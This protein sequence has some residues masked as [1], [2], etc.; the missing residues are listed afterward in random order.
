M[1]LC[2]ILAVVMVFAFA[3]T[4]LPET[5]TAYADEPPYG[6][7]VTLIGTDGTQLGSLGTATAYLVNNELAASG[8]LGEDGCTAFM[9]VDNAV[10][11][12]QNY[13][14][15]PIAQYTSSLSLKVVIAGT[16]TINV[17]T[18]NDLTLFGLWARSGLIEITSTTGGTLNINVTNNNENKTGSI[19]G[20]GAGMVGGEYYGQVKVSGDA[21]VNV[22]V[23]NNSTYGLA[24]TNGIAVYDG[25]AFV[26]SSNVSIRVK[27]SSNA[28]NAAYAIYRN[29]D[30][31]PI[32]FD[33]TGNVTLDN[34]ESIIDAGYNTLVIGANY[35][36]A[37]VGTIKCT[38]LKDSR[39]YGYET[40]FYE[41]NYIPDLPSTVVRSKYVVGDLVTTTYKNKSTATFDIMYNANGGTGMMSETPKPYNVN[42]R[43]LKNQ[44]AAP[45]HMQFKCWDVNGEEIDAD[46]LIEITSDKLIKA[47]WETAQYTISFDANGGSGSIADIVKEYGDTCALPANS[48]L[49]APQGQQ[50]KCW[51]IAGVE[52][53]V[54]YEFTVAENVTVLAVWEDI[55]VETYTVTYKA[56]GGSGEDVVVNDLAGTY[57]PAANTF[58]APEHQRFAGWATTADGKVITTPTIVV[59]A[60]IELFAIWQDITFSITFAAEDGSGSMPVVNVIEDGSYV[61]P[62]NAFTAPAGKQF[63]GWN[64]FGKTY[65]A[66]YELNNINQDLRVAAIWEDIPVDPEPEYHHDTVDGVEVYGDTLTAGVAK[67]VAALFAEAKAENGKV[68]LTLDTLSISFNTAAVSAIGDAAA[69]ISANVLTSD[70]DV[71]GAQM[72]IEINLTGATFESGKASISI[73]FATVVPDGKVAKVYYI[74]AQGNKTDMNA[75]FADGK[76]TFDTNHFSRFAVVF[77]DPQMVE[78]TLEPA[79]AKQGL[80]GGAIAGIVIGAVVL[81]AGI[82]VGVFFI[83]KK[84]K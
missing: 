66:G 38:Y 30:E 29:Q 56:N 59:E 79:P 73:P 54:G 22:N 5:T 43:L 62:E 18:A 45:T 72:I 60:D 8:T 61:L 2:G 70:L 52:R 1:V 63:A 41:K 11:Y 13:D 50:F 15:G 32:V 10:L 33:T 74:D 28:S 14:F 51:S 67:D 31:T 21:T 37:N 68:E 49:T 65:A 34:S 23:V 42:Y 82:A 19:Y 53:A 7:S 55:P 39:G 40:D 75:V 17:A 48:G 9:D 26:D 4:L 6:T 46:T 16:N 36:F 44:F 64:I 58:A 20:I 81:A 76:V 69:T 77:E 57:T 47:V 12:L 25:A 83:L 24:K 80:S 84:K 35:S 27:S 78:P 71:E 3:I